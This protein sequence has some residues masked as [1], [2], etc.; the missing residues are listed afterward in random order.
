MAQEPRPSQAIW[1]RRGNPTQGPSAGD[2]Y[3][4]SWARGDP[5]IDLLSP[6]LDEDIDAMFASI[7]RWGRVLFRSEL[8]NNEKRA[9]METV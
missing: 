5:Y 2:D 8:H 3:P 7:A 6:T 9:E 4:N 1:A